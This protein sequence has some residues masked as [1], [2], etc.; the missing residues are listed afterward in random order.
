MHNNAVAA[1][2]VDKM[3]HVTVRTALKYSY[4][5]EMPKLYDCDIFIV[6][7]SCPQESRTGKCRKSHH[8]YSAARHARVNHMQII[9]ARSMQSHS[10]R[11]NAKV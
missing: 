7:L 8:S 5:N 1:V 4:T 2:N 9:E 3:C 11:N 6:R 10:L